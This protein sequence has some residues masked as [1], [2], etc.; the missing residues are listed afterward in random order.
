VLFCCDKRRIFW[1][2]WLGCERKNEEL[3]GLNVV[4]AAALRLAVCATGSL[5]ATRDGGK[6]DCMQP[7]FG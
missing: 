7:C 3:E 2:V 4:V 5:E 6:I 1:T